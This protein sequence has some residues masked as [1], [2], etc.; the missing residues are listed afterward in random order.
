M[1]RRIFFE[2]NVSE[3]SCGTIRE[4]RTKQLVVMSRGLNSK[5][6]SVALCVNCLLLLFLAPEIPREKGAALAA[7]P[8]NHNHTDSNPLVALVVKFSSN[9]YLRS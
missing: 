4:S 8:I 1:S 9:S 3:S 2:R 7:A 6:S 5:V